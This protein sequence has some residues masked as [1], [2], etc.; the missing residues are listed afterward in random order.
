M[1][2][3][4]NYNTG[5]LGAP[6]AAYQDYS[7]KANYA[8]ERDRISDHQ[9]F[10]EQPTKEY[11]AGILRT[12]NKW[13]N[14]LEAWQQTR[15]QNEDEQVARDVAMMSLSASISDSH[16]TYQLALQCHVMT[17]KEFK[18][19]QQQHDIFPAVRPEKEDGAALEKKLAAELE[20]DISSTATSKPVV[21]VQRRG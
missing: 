12:R 7:A 1:S 19:W 3:P 8:R 16:M 14:E 6:T 13:Q 21:P 5:V 20:A 15:P 11:L 18:M 4:D 2:Y 17:A 9:R 10:A